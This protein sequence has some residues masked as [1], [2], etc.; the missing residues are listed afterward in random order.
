[1]QEE[2]ILSCDNTH[3]IIVRLIVVGQSLGLTLL[4]KLKIHTILNLFH[5]KL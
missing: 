5:P 2:E 1:M 3:G 4:V